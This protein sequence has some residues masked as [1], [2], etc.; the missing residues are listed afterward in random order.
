[1]NI[2]EASKIYYFCCEMSKDNWVTWANDEKCW[3]VC[4]VV[5]R[6]DMVVDGDTSWSLL[7]SL[8]GALMNDLTTSLP[9]RPNR[10]KWP[11]HKDLGQQTRSC[12]T[13]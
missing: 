8:T 2:L 9:Q 11:H 6:R 13:F 4:D 1:M 7:M 3:L 5:V 10:N 12:V